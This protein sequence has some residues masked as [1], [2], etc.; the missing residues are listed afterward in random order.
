MGMPAFAAARNKPAIILILADDLGYGDLG[1]YGSDIVRT[2]N[3][4]R[5]AARGLRFTDFHSSGAVCSPTRAGLMTGRYQQRAGVPEVITVNHRHHGMSTSETTFPELLRKAGYRTGIFG[6][7]HLGYQPKFSPVHQGFD[8]FRGYVSG[9]VDYFSH[10]DGAGYADWWNGDKLQPET[11]YV[12]DLITSH[13]VR[14]IEQNKDRPFFL[15]IAHE[16]VHSPWQGPKD[17]PFREVGKQ[18]PQPKG[19]HR[20]AFREMLE[21]LDRSVGAVIDA[22][23]RAGRENDTLIFFTSD[24]GAPAMGSNG[25]LR[26]HKGTVWE[27]GHRVPAVAYWPGQIKAGESDVT[28]IT[29]DLFPT[30]VEVADASKGDRKLDGTS[31]LSHL[32]KGTPVAERT[33]FWGHAQQRAMRQGKWKLVMQPKSEPA[34][35]DLQSDRS[36]KRDLA[37]QQPERTRTMRDAIAA[38]E[39]E[40]GA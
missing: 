2:P 14:F 11:G 8:E 20:T 25:S 29:L 16:A 30:F 15:Y 36:E 34:L 27:G 39:K 24:N 40:V 32:T 31:L 18:N 33:L 35:F 21:A 6:K 4:D 9:N 13:S 10:V 1:C 22:V 37:S 23:R 12:T 19:N 5:L 17:K 7:W 28:G 26:G 38:W 3:I